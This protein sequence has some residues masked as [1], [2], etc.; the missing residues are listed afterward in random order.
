MLHADFCAL[1]R[2]DGTNPGRRLVDAVASGCVPLLIGDAMRP[3]L[4]AFLRYETFSV[5]V[6]SL[7]QR[8]ALPLKRV[9]VE[10]RCR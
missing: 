1:P 9:A 5:R 6:P 7:T 3:P 10:A 2:G 4:S 8:S